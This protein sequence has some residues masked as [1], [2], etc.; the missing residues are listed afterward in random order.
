[1]LER[2]RRLVTALTLVALR[3]LERIYI[4]IYIYIYRVP[5]CHRNIRVR[6]GKARTL[7]LRVTEGLGVK[8][9]TG[10]WERSTS[11]LLSMN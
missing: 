1:M 4:Y 9:P 7:G 3:I 11:V 5:E 8:R 2:R 10:T 6:S